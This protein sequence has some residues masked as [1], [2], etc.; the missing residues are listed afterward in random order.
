MTD[1]FGL[2]LAPVSHSQPPGLSVAAKMSGTY[3][4]RSSVSSASA[5]LQQSLANRLAELL[6]SHG[7]TMF[8]LTWKAIRTPLLRP[9]CQ[10]RA[11]AHRTSGSDFGGL[12]TIG[13]NEMKGSSRVRFVGSPHF[14]GAKT[15]EGLRTTEADPIYLNPSFGRLLMGYPTAW[16]DCAVTATP[17]SRKSRKHSSA[18]R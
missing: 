1:L 14:R 12:P 5:I 15:S 4:L 16:D 11:S 10:Q 6:D 7:S 8:A 3:G 17:S 9:I 2:V 13:A 18:Q